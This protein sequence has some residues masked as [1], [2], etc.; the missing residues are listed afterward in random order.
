MSLTVA[1]IDSAIETILTTGQSYKID[2]VEYTRADLDKLR[3]LRREIQ[4]EEAVATQGTIFSRSL[5]GSPRRH[6]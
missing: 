3:L 1:Q 2:D 6:F 4:G 5:I